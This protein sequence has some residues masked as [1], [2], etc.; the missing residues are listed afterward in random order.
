MTFD[1]NNNNSGFPSSSLHQ[2]DWF[3]QYLPFQQGLGLQFPTW[4]QSFTWP[5]I[6]GQEEPEGIL[7]DFQKDFITRH[8]NKLNEG[9]TGDITATPGFDGNQFT[10]TTLQGSTISNNLARI[11]SS[12]LG[13]IG[14]TVFNNYVKGDNLFTGLNTDVKNSVIGAGVGLASNLVGQG[15]SSADSMLSRGIGQGVSTGLSQVGTRLLTNGSKNLFGTMR[16]ITDA[17]NKMKNA[18]NAAEAS[19]YAS[20]AS[21]INPWALGANVVGQGLSAAFGPSKEYGGTN[22]NITKT[23]DTAYDIVQGAVGFVPGW[24]QIAAGAMALNKGLSN[25]FGSTDGMTTQDAILGSAF[26]PAPIKWVN[27]AGA[28]TTDT[29]N[30]YNVRNQQLTNS[31]MQNAFGNLNEKFEKAFNESGKT[32][33]T[34]SRGAYRRANNNINYSN[35]AFDSVLDMAIQNDIQN[36]RSQEMSSINNQRYSQM[37]QGGY[38]PLLVGK[39]GMKISN[40]QLLSDA[41]LIDKQTILCN[42]QN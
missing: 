3:Q 25:I 20:R 22:G 24:G 23:M 38:Q 42:V 12:G 10:D 16:S 15:I 4:N 11:F 17:T 28:K 31:F 29:F 18:S 5:T 33:G 8:T 37:I 1:I 36:T 13:S 2:N 21:A 7:P 30:N 27:M 6:A 32:Y 19:K 9:L 35:K 14:N 40:Q 41:A 34:F 39:Q 26:M